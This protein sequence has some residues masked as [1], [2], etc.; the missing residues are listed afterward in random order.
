LVS[1][2][3]TSLAEVVGNGGILV[4]PADMDAVIAASFE[5]FK[6]HVLRDS[7]RSRGLAQA[8]SLSWP[9]AGERLKNIW[10]S[11]LNSA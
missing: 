5:V 8:G 9:S 1:S 2:N 11:A 3:R 7:L 4:D 10:E 6:N